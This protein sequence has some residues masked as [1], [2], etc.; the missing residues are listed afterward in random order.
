[1]L[2]LINDR[3]SEAPLSEES[4]LG[5]PRLRQHLVKLVGASVRVLA[6]TLATLA[7]LVN[8]STANAQARS[9]PLRLVSK[10]A[11][12]VDL[13]ANQPTAI[14][15]GITSQRIQTVVELRL[16]R[17]GLRVLAPDAV[18]S[19]PDV[20]PIV[21]MS[22]KLVEVLIDGRRNGYAYAHELEVYTWGPDALN[23]ARVPQV[24]FSFS[25]VSVTETQVAAER[26][27]TSIQR[28]LDDFVNEWLADNPGRAR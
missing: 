28:A 23:G 2:F 1:M 4:T 20:V 11:V 5:Q 9:G 24:L 10:V 3:G 18:A 14:P 13:D 17:A 19:D 16:R 12:Y 6:P 15:A 25:S 22:I 8:T 7:C 21:Q 26:I 27:E